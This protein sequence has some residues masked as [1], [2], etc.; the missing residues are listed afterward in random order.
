GALILSLQNGVD[1]AER[2]AAAVP[3]PVY[4]AVVYVGAE[5]DAPGR[6]RHTGRGD[7]VIGLPRRVPARGDAAKD[8]SAISRMFEN[9]GV[10]CP[11]AADIDAALWTK[12]AINCAC[13]P[14]S[15]LANARYGAMLAH[16][17]T[18]ELMERIVRE[19]ADIAAADGI[20]VDA[21]SLVEAVWQVAG[22]MPAQQSSTAQDLQRGK[23]TEIDAINGFVVQRARALGRDAP[24]NYSLHALVKARE[25]AARE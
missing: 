6:V 22:A 9:A 5:A 16:A 7:L 14:V 12:L 11:V 18:R 13:N 1:N 17:P 4:A 8:L 20:R 25:A 19:T 3:N 24:V 10:R 23:P 2:I 15:A 21:D